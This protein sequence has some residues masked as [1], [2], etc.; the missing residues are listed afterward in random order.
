MALVRGEREPGPFAISAQGAE[1]PETPRYGACGRNF[2]LRGGGNFV[3]CADSFPKTPSRCASA[4]TLGIPGTADLAS[5]STSHKARPAPP[6][7]TSGHR[8]SPRL[9]P[10][11][12]IPAASPP[13]PRPLPCPACPPRRIPA[14]SPAPPCLPCPGCPALAALP[15]LPCPGCPALAALPWLPC[16]GCPALAAL[17]W[18]PRNLD[19]YFLALTAHCGS[20]RGV[21]TRCRLG[22]GAWPA[23]C[24]RRN[25]ALRFSAATRGAGPGPARGRVRR[26]AGSG[27][28]RGRGR[29]GSGPARGRGRRGV[30]VG[31]GV[32][33]GSGC[34]SSWGCGGVRWSGDLL[35]C[36]R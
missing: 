34:G 16:P 35:L 4:P 21:S 2:C 20:S 12:R 1:P 26:G 19:C 28:V 24:E 11:R 9:A 17:P 8:I 25:Q 23:L 29:R 14:P 36:G 30:G 13:H 3:R 6:R 15:W 22:R 10:A 27:P 18:H 31:A 5:R 7:P 32:G 33:A